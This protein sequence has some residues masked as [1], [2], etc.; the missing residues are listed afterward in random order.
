MKTAIEKERVAAIQR[1]SPS[2]A[3]DGFL[4]ELEPRLGG[5]SGVGNAQPG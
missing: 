2:E 3:P 1:Q 5:S 4:P